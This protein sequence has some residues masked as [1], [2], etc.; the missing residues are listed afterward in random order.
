MGEIDHA[1]NPE[2]HRIADRD[3]AVD[4]TERQPVDHLL[5]QIIH[6]F[7]RIFGRDRLILLAILIPIRFLATVQEVDNRS[8][9]DLSHKSNF[10]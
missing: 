3:Q 5:R 10:L 9:S 4:R 2:H 8:V 6:A 7:P 1:D